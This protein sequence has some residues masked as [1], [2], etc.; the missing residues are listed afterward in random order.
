MGFSLIE[1]N[2]SR[3]SPIN[4]KASLDI[5]VIVSAIS[6]EFGYTDTRHEPITMPTLS[7]EIRKRA[8]PRERI[9]EARTRRV[10]REKLMLFSCLSS[11]FSLFDAR[12]PG[13]SS[14]L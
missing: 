11:P 2:E 3:M 6:E 10:R 9:T 7:A 1:L 4:E 14:R 8:S 12:R 13:D 5:G